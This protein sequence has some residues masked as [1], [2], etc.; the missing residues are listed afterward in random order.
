M[1][2]TLD[3]RAEDYA[4]KPIEIIIETWPILSN[5]QGIRI[6]FLLRRGKSNTDFLRKRLYRKIKGNKIFKKYTGLYIFL[7]ESDP[8]TIVKELPKICGDSGKLLYEENEE[9]PSHSILVEGR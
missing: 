5:K 2:E 9:F 7:L 3:I 1:R 8:V 6:E 4:L